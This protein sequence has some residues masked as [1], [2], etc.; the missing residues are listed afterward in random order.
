[1]QMSRERSQSRN[2]ITEKGRAMGW[3][4]LKEHYGIRHQVAVYP[5]KGICIGS[6][7]V[8]DIIVIADTDHPLEWHDRTYKR[9]M[10]IGCGLTIW[11]GDTIGRGE[12]FDGLVERWQA[13][14]KELRNTIDEPDTFGRSIP[15]YTYDYDGNIIMHV[16]EE[17]GWPHVTHDGRMMYENTFSIDRGQVREWA[18]R[19]L[20]AAAV[21][22]RRGIKD[23]EARL[24]ERRAQL[25]GYENG[26][27]NLAATP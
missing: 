7:Y 3:K 4:R 11:R 6:A 23:D 18:K 14:P 8:H 17:P 22:V 5:E 25:A 16:C 13:Y 1:M 26:L 21:S 15:V 20:I 12:P 27:R 19:E 9:P 10:N 2:E 24:A